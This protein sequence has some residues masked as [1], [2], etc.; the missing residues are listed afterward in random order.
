MTVLKYNERQ[1]S[2]FDFQES[3]K[4]RKLF[5]QQ[6]RKTFGLPAVPDTIEMLKAC[7]SKV[8]LFDLKS[9]EFLCQMLIMNFDGRDP[10]E[11]QLT[12]LHNLFSKVV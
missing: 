6:A 7:A 1:L 10:S 8:N 12:Y 3:T 11:R 4:T 2:M 9:R 5:V